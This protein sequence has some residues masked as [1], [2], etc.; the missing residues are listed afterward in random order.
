M[1]ILLA[2]TGRDCPTCICMYK[3]DKKSHVPA[4]CSEVLCVRPED[5]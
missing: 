2:G 4:L 5:D 3:A 1:S